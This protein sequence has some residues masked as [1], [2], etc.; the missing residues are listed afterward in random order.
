MW[1]II[2]SLVFF[3]LS[4]EELIVT[5]NYIGFKFSL[6]VLWVSSIWEV[7]GKGREEFGGI[8]LEENIE[9]FF[10]FFRSV[11]VDNDN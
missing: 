11:F 6:S 8:K 1:P 9:K 3:I 2:S 7:G 10:N 4:V 5:L